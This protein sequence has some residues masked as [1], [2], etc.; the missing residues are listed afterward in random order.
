MRELILD[1]NEFAD[2]AAVH[3][4]LADGLDF[5]DYYGANLD[6]LYDC[7]GE[8]CEPTRLVVR[9]AEGESQ[10]WF[11]R[12]CVVLNDAAEENECLDVIVYTDD[13]TEDEVDQATS[14]SAEDALERLRAG[15]AEYLQAHAASAN[16]SNE[17]VEQLFHEGQRPYA[18]I[19]TCADSRV[20]PEH[21]FM[22]GLGELFVIRVAGN[23][24]GPSEIASAIYACS[25]LDVKLLV[26]LGHTHC[27]AIEAA[28]EDEAH[29]AVGQITQRIAHAIGDERDPYAA[30]VLNVRAAVAMLEGHLELATLMDAGLEV[31]GAIYHTHSGV[32]DFLQ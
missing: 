14:M 8:I 16:I 2:A 11:E 27:G 17:L 28:M 32:V 18:V 30:S 23:I 6:A 20:V 13:L 9:R 21:L 5:P 15:N 19:L 1:Q 31:H 10:A 7:L 12:F 26:V 25:H 3:R 22:T 29:G 4:A 24:A